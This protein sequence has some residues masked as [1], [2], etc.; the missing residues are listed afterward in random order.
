MKKSK[1]Q[2]N[3]ALYGQNFIKYTQTEY[4]PIENKKAKK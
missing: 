4:I 1:V 2:N 3:N